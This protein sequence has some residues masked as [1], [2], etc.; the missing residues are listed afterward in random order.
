MSLNGFISDFVLLDGGSSSESIN[1]FAGR[2]ITVQELS[3]PS[4]ELD[5]RPLYQLDSRPSYKLESD[6]VYELDDGRTH[7]E[8][9]DRNNESN[10]IKPKTYQAYHPGLID[11]N[12]GFRAELSTNSTTES[13][14]LGEV[15]SSYHSLRVGEIDS[16]HWELHNRISNPELYPTDLNRE[17]QSNASSEYLGLIKGSVYSNTSVAKKTVRFE[18]QNTNS[19]LK[20]LGKGWIDLFKKSSIKKESYVEGGV[21]ENGGDL[22]RYYN[23]ECT[24]FTKKN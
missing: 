9:W 10:S 17:V 13:T 18:D 5:S 23:S 14:L 3:R 12:Q 7:Y 21:W 1:D 6:P 16:Q 4:Y 15:R 11:T 8:L 24:V 2:P 20:K 19:I 22:R